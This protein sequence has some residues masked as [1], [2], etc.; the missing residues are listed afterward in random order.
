MRAKETRA[1]IEIVA[2]IPI[3]SAS[4]RRQ[5][6]GI[7]TTV[8]TATKA[9]SSFWIRESEAAAHGGAQADGLKR[10]RAQ[11]GRTLTISRL[12][13]AGGKIEDRGAAKID[14]I[15]CQKVAFIHPPNITFTRYFD[16]ATGRL[17]QTDTDDGG[18]TAGGGRTGSSRAC[19][20]RLDE[21]DDQVRQG[22]APARLD[23]LRPDRREREV[24]CGH[25]SDAE[26]ESRRSEAFC[27]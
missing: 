2:R 6:K 22:A 24:S 26:S 10:L 5:D 19:R 15:D 25:V 20:F 9:G 17:V 23:R 16:K 21:D 18:S 3:S 8:S 13:R 4:S 12:E 1:K 11:R 27:W 7:E 14:G